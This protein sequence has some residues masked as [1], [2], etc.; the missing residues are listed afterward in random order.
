MNS[1]W[2][3]VIVQSTSIFIYS[4]RANQT[5]GFFKFSADLF[6]LFSGVDNGAAGV[7]SRYTEMTGFSG[8]QTQ[9]TL[10]VQLTS[11]RMWSQRI[12]QKY[13]PLII[14]LFCAMIALMISVFIASIITRLSWCLLNPCCSSIVVGKNLFCFV[15]G[16][17]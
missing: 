2:L 16:T 13:V 4:S 11:A 9:F 17:W 14:L 15:T 8:S 12:S 5:T 10:H 6:Y 1:M 3:G 7:A